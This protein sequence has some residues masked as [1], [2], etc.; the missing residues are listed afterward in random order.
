MK[1]MHTA[2]WHLGKIVNGASMLDEQRYILR[3]IIE[4]AKDEEVDGIIIAGDI[5]DRSVPPT[6]AVNMLNDTLYELNVLRQ[7]PLFIIAGNHDSADRLSFGSAWYEQHKL[8]LA[9]KLTPTIM[10]IDWNG[11][12][13]WL[14]P[15]HDAL[16]ARSVL[17]DDSI[18][19]FDDA[20]RVITGKIALVQDKTKLQICVGHAFVAGGLPTDSERQLA[21]GNA[22]RVAVDH[23][24][25]FDYVALGH[26]H[27]PHAL[28]NEKIIYSGSPL[29][30]S[31]SEAKDKKSVRIIEFKDDATISVSEKF[32]KPAHDLQIIEGYLEELLIRT[33]IVKTDYLQ[34]NLLDE[35]ALIDPIGKL[36]AVYPNI[37]H[38]ERKRPKLVGG[39]HERFED[40]VKK[41]EVQLFAQFF[42]YT[43][44]KELNENQMD[45]L[46]NVVDK[47]KRGEK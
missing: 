28:K 22:D 34:I 5:Y 11:A 39:N 1:I 46:K 38:L 36:R 16:S 6:E 2:D 40:V 19:T 41:D 45:I 8:F 10:P 44:A 31:F 12:Q 18:K 25:I 42:N 7:I 14:I 23:F 43:M 21:I 27:N 15:Y 13:I 9:G 20:M 47:V 3:Q 26:L 29:K 17:Q 4:I 35:G 33:D 30:Y 24:E 37:L 32:L